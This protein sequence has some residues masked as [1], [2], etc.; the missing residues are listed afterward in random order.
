MAAS[1][2][3]AQGGPARGIGVAGLV[4][5][6]RH[7]VRGWSRIAAAPDGAGSLL[8]GAALPLA[9]IRPAARLV[10][11]LAF[12]RET[13]GIIQY[14]PTTAGA[15]VTALA[16]WAL[17]VTAVLLLSLV[18]AALAP[19]FDGSRDRVAALKLA[20]YGCAPYF[21]ASIF[22]LVPA[23]DF[24]QILGLYAFPLLAIGVRP[25]MHVP[26]ERAGRVGPLIAG[27]ALILGAAQLWAAGA[28]ATRWL[29]PTIKTAGRRVV[30]KNA[31]TI[32]GVAVTA[33]ANT[34]ANAAAPGIENGGAAV[35]ASSLQA[36]LPA[37]V[38]GFQRTSV[39]S[40]S[41]T[42]LGVTTAN[43]KGTY[44]EG[45]DSF[46]LTITDAG[47]PGALATSNSVI[48]GELNRVTDAG[49]QRSRVVDGVRIVEK[50][51]NADRGG[52]YSR[53]VVGRFTIEAA[54]TAPTIGTL[55]AA[56]GSVDQRRLAI[57]A[58]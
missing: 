29:E 11:D 28:I 16:T 46:T 3:A 58:P 24:L 57:L 39:D 6:L 21:I 45:T 12:G 13:M 33:P 34:K 2:V 55:K 42:S 35:P 38:G 22:L 23:I 48:A 56:V 30:V 9:A 20:S 32:A 8:I 44:I 14:R 25:M 37:R 18:I 10:H 50:W 54:G 47:Q 52:G 53:T 5:V 43:A 4:G 7:P 1:S 40:Q 41:S 36:L 27:I 49:Y 17:A 26:R 19:R 31:P 51:N 15:V